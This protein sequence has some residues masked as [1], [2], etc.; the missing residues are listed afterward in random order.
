[1]T[2]TT[3][4][5]TA[6]TRW[7]V[8]ALAAAALLSGCASSTG[9]EPAAPED[10]RT[11]AGVSTAT[12]EPAATPTGTGGTSSSPAPSP[13]PSTATSEATPAGAGAV[14]TGLVE[15]PFSGYDDIREEVVAWSLECPPDFDG[16]VPQQATTM[17]TAGQELDA[18]AF[19]RRQVA[20]FDSVADAEQAAEEIGRYARE[21]CAGEYEPQPGFVASSS[22]VEPLE[23]GEQAFLVDTTAEDS[24]FATALLR[25]GTAVALVSASSGPE[26]PQGRSA[27]EDVRAAVP[28]LHEQLCRYEDGAC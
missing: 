18:E 14:P 12:P 16:V 26:Y 8:T 15:A 27:V 11:D 10:V 2:G 13:A 9:A 22:T 21:Q 3:T 5:H 20:V 4:T 1:M 25:R 7:S 17:G 6:P 19:T 28:S 24:S 23:A